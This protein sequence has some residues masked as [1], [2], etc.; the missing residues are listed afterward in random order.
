MSRFL[1]LIFVLCSACKIQVTMNGSVVPEEAET[2]S[3][4]YFTSQTALAAPTASQTFTEALRDL[5][6]QQSNLDL[7]ETDGDLHFEGF[8][9][10]YAT[11]PVALQGNETAALNRL[12]IS[13]K[14]KYENRF[15]EEA[16]FESS[17]SR[18]ADYDSSLDLSAVED[19]LI[20][21]IT[22]QLVQ[23]IYN[24]AFGNW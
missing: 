16:N 3:V 13:V 19:D 5:M 17:F 15:D 23:D 6:L 12:T 1:I 14:V 21:E 11:S 2:F 4:N 9:T 8:I 22:D 10:G 24:Q 7:V 18:F 20:I